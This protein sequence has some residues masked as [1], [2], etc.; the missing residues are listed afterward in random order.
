MLEQ[1]GRATEALCERVG[2]YLRLLI[3]A[4]KG[5]LSPP[6]YGHFFLKHAEEI[7]VHSLPVVLLTALF[8][9]MVLALQSYSAF[10]RFGADSMIAMVVSLSI[11]RE[12]GPVLVGMMVAGRV[13]AAFAAEIGTMRVTEQIDALWT[14]ST[15]PL[16]YLVIPRILAAM[17]MLPMLVVIANFIGIFG[18]FAISTL[19]LEQNPNLYIEQTIDFMKPAD[20][21]SGIIKSAFFGLLI[22]TIGC[23][24]GFYCQGGA[25]GVGKATTRAVVSICMSILIMDYILTSWMFT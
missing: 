21:Y 19:M 1:T 5:L 24:E 18:G 9:G 11:V 17:F 2:L 25:Q 6:W 20:F 4:T 13:G 15:D 12:L 22:G 23:A 14:L 8:T 16:R 10:H 7:G 3:D